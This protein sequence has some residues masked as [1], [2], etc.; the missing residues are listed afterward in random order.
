MLASTM[1]YHC[2][3]L[4]QTDKED[5]II[6]PKGETL[7]I[8]NKSMYIPVVSVVITAFREPLAI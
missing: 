5:V 1:V 8:C 7:R 4:A 2:F 3:Y 6:G